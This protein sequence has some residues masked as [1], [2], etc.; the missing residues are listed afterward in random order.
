[1]AGLPEDLKTWGRLLERGEGQVRLLTGAGAEQFAAFEGFS[2]VDNGTL[3]C[4]R[5]RRRYDRLRQQAE[6]FHTSHPFLPPGDR[7]PMDTVG[8]VARD[9]S[10]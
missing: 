10:F 1:M 7:M 5:E 2:L 9:R 4:E 3:I 6:R 8:C